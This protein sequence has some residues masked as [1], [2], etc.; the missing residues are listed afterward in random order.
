MFKLSQTIRMEKQGTPVSDTVEN[1]HEELARRHSAAVQVV[2]GVFLVTLILM[3]LALSGVLV[4]AAGRNPAM[5]GAM[6]I[7]IVV[8]GIGAVVFR[9][10]MFSSMRLQDVAALRGTS[11]LIRMLQSTTVYVALIG[12][13]IAVMAFTVS[14]MTG[15]GWDMVRLGVIAVAVLLYA[16]PRRAAWERVVE[17]TGPSEAGAERAAKGSIA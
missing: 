14:M 6:L 17:A 13:A 11:A 7:A 12:G 10:T 1:A 9:R 2:V 15:F 3:A 16:Y 5:E 8:F 4:G